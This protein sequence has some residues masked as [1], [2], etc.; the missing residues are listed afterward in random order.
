M[1]ARKT[2][3]LFHMAYFGASDLDELEEIK[4]NLGLLEE[5]KKIVKVK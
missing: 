2:I 1:A 3:G 4:D 5:P